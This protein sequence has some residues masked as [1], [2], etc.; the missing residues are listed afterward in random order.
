MFLCF[1]NVLYF[2]CFS[3][4][5]LLFKVFFVFLYVFHIFLNSDFVVFMFYYV[6]KFSSFVF[7]FFIFLFYVFRFFFICSQFSSCLFNDVIIDVF[8]LLFLHS[9]S[10]ISLFY[11]F[12]SFGLSSFH[13]T[14]PYFF[15]VFF[16]SLFPDIFIFLFLNGW[17]LGSFFI[18]PCFLPLS[19]FPPWSSYVSL[20]VRQGKTRQP[21][22]R[23]AKP[24]RVCSHH[25]AGTALCTQGV[26]FVFR[27][28]LKHHHHNNK[29]REVV[30]LA[31]V[32]VVSSSCKC[33]CE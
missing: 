33:S 16:I 14:V 19:F 31:I 6:L 24:S 3:L 10:F 20:P 8:P 4:F 1:F 23:Q 9:Y 32:V 2:S 12:L 30:V 26:Q 17:C 13:S 25:R 18:Y 28:L 7:T 27:K 5:S 22:A 15:N 21:K 29:L 11:C